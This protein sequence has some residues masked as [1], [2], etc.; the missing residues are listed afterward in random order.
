MWFSYFKIT[1]TGEIMNDLYVVVGLGSSGFSSA[2]YLI[3]QGL[4]VAITDTRQNP[5]NLTDFLK[6]FPDVP[7]SLGKLDEALL[8]KASEIVISPGISLQEPAI[9]R[10]I[11]HG[12]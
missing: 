1:L 3:Q 10:Q 11:A 2:R 4:P 6:E 9:A 5:P 7:V 12:T 8:A